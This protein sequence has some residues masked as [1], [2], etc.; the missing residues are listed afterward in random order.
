MARGLGGG[1]LRA[2]GCTLH[3]EEKAVACTLHG[4]SRGLA[5]GLEGSSSHSEHLLGAE[6]GQQPRGKA[7]TTRGLPGLPPLPAGGKLT[8]WEGEGQ[9]D[10]LPDARR[11]ERGERLVG[12]ERGGPG[13]ASG[14]GWLMSRLLEES[15]RERRVP[16]RVL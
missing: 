6:P 14:P 15:D 16:N 2:Q 3:T 8:G 4:N 5:P 7:L 1:G 9:K 10:R 13:P 12:L 11:M